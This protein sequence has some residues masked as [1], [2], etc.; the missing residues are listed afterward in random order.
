VITVNGTIASD[1]SVML[2][3]N[4]R[5]MNKK[6]KVF[7]LAD[8]G[9]SEDKT[10]MIDYGAD[11]FAVKPLSMQSLI[12]KVNMKLL[13]EAAKSSSSSYAKEKSHP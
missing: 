9:L 3:L 12:N 5:R 1:R 8:R 10:R 11:E 2:I 4:V 7:V 6:V 13:E